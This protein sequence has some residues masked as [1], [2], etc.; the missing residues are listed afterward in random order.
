LVIVGLLGIAASSPLPGEDTSFDSSPVLSSSTPPAPSNFHCEKLSTPLKTKCSWDAIPADSLADGD[1]AMGYT[2]RYW[3]QGSEH[4][5]SDEVDLAARATEAVIKHI[6]P[7]GNHLAFQ[8]R[9]YTSYYEGEPS[10][11]ILV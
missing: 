3:V 7:N 6:N 11:V 8:I 4:E 2:I 1:S 10:P 9:F 5:T